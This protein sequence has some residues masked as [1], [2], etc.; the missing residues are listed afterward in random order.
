MATF[1]E[2]LSTLNENKL[3]PNFYKTP[4]SWYISSNRPELVTATGAKVIALGLLI[5]RLK[6]KELLD[7]QPSLAT[8]PNVDGTAQCT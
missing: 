2:L 3:K 4:H 7:N 6:G 1:R 8:V 5:R